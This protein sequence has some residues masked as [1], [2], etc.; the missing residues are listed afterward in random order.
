MRAAAPFR[1][2]EPQ[3]E[4]LARGRRLAWWSLA[5]LASTAILIYLTLGSSQAMKTA[6]VEDLLSFIPPIAFLY[7]ARVTRRPPDRGFPFG[8]QRATTIAYLCGALA[9][10]V[11]GALLL[12]DA[13]LVL[14][15][16]EHPTIGTVELLG[17]PVWLGWLMIAALTWGAVPVVFLGRAKLRL[18]RVLHDKVLHADGKMNKADWL[19]ATAAILGVLGIGAGWWWADAAAA[20]L[21]SLDV[22]HDGVK[23]LRIAVGDLMDRAPRTVDHA[24]ED[25]LPNVLE[26]FLRRQRWVRD[27]EVRVR[28][29]GHVFYADALV[30]PKHE[31]GLVEN[32]AH[33][34]AGALELDW[35]LHDLVVM[36]VRELPRVPSG[37][38]HGP[39]SI[40]RAGRRD[41]EAEHPSPGASNSPVVH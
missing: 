15:A 23:H 9:L 21:I 35:R 32:V 25:P 26:K 11:M 12:V 38:R 31:R 22:G 28:E 39:G 27:V 16:A 37:A 33:A 36:P 4:A 18:A 17:R 14:A 13:A 7:S 29:E 3:R 5:Y 8:Y 19:T 30:V 40:E 6:W 24:R 20:A 10:F 41:V 1:L 2:P 34:T